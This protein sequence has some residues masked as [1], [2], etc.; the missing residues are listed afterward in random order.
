MGF[1]TERAFYKLIRP[2]RNRVSL[3]VGR[4]VV[5]AT[6]EDGGRLYVKMSALQGETLDGPEI[7]QQYG[8]A[9]RPHPEA[10][11]IFVSVGGDRSHAVGIATEDERYRPKD[12]EVGESI[13]YDDQEQMVAIRRDHIEIIS[14]KKIIVDAPIVEVTANAVDVAATAVSITAET[15]KLDSSNIDIGGDGEEDAP[16][17]ARVGDQVDNGIIISGSDKM[18]CR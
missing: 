6:I 12:L 16:A 2:L 13:L 7:F 14:S 18:R 11:V 3:L 5:R 15:V 9:S 1:L 10:E 8:Q 17:V 4:A